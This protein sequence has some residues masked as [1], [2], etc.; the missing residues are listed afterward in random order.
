METSRTL[1]AAKV[2][3]PTHPINEPNRRTVYDDHE[4][5]AVNDF[6]LVIGGRRVKGAVHFARRRRGVRRTPRGAD[7][8]RAWR[9]R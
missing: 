1:S 6:R 4:E 3:N 5:E 8:V 7:I 9:A 2:P